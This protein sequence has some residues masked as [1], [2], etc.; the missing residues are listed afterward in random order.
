MAR[1]DASSSHRCCG[2]M[3]AASVIS[4]SVHEATQ[5]IVILGFL[6]PS[7][8]RKE[9]RI[10]CSWIFSEEIASSCRHLMSILASLNRARRG[11][12]ASESAYCILDL[13]TVVE[14]AIDVGTRFWPF[15]H[16][17]FSFLQNIPECIL[18]FNP[19]WQPEGESG[20]GYGLHIDST[21]FRHSLHERV[22]V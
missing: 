21:C 17:I 22:K 18:I 12:G 2:S 9:R 4:L 6:T 19:L 1:Y 14:Q 5:C 10:E 3:A 8:Y 16:D 11:Q 7:R 15:C 20:N 13:R